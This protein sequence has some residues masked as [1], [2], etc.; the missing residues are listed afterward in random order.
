MAISMVEALQTIAVEDLSP[1]I[2]ETL[3]DIDPI[4]NLI[5]DSWEGVDRNEIGRPAVDANGALVYGSTWV[6]RWIWKASGGGAFKYTNPSPDIVT[7]TG[8]HHRVY[9]SNSGFPGITDFVHGSFAN[10]YVGLKEGRGTLIAPWQLLQADQFESVL[11]EMSA[12]QIADSA[13]LTAHSEAICWTSR[14]P[15][16][17]EV[18]RT[19]AYK[20]AGASNPLVTTYASV[21]ETD[22]AGT[23][24]DYRISFFPN[25]TSPAAYPALDKYD[26]ITRLRPGMSVDIWEVD[27]DMVDSGESVD[28]VKL[29][30][31]G[32]V[33]DNVD[34][35]NGAV[36]FYSKDGAAIDNAVGAAGAENDV[37]CYIV[38]LQ[39]TC[40]LA[41]S[42]VDITGETA[43]LAAINAA[44]SGS[45]ALQDA[46]DALLNDTD[47][48]ALSTYYK[49]GPGGLAD[50]IKTEYTDSLYGVSMTK[51]PNLLSMKYD[52]MSTAGG[53]AEDYM[54]EKLADRLVG[55][56]H[57]QYGPRQAPD[58]ILSTNG[59]L[60]GWAHNHRSSPANSSAGVQIRETYDRTGK[61]ISQTLGFKNLTYGYR[62]MDYNI[63]DSPMVPRKTLRFIR[64]RDKN[65]QRLTPPP[66]PGAGG[67]EKFRD[68]QFVVPLA[69][70][71]KGVFKWAHDGDGKVT[72]YVEAPYVV[73]HQH[74]VQKP[75]ALEVVGI[76]EIDALNS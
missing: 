7:A 17:G 43:H 66:I 67:K 63:V 48:F 10:P 38:T 40:N 29:N 41:A 47:V 35:I 69:G 58:T 26:S 8:D 1:G 37:M 18:C 51:M 68:V 56:Y 70:Q 23:A 50:W 3:P 25:A 75:Q 76:K 31:P 19:P 39:G 54:S 20:A 34:Y 59:V 24:N 44:T 57:S 49:Y 61:G 60:A 55:W 53:G 62:G 27:L 65:F 32:F 22:I 42:G 9:A 11:A 2:R 14:N 33:V 46:I 12:E 45:K 71:G 73:M 36:S 30:A 15:S 4:F 5:Y 16:W 21:G 72:D 64:T 6:K 74:Y 13:E 28:I 52:F